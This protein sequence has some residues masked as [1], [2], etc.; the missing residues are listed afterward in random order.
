MIG[1]LGRLLF[2]PGHYAYVGSA[3]GGLRG[4]LERHLRSEKKTRWHIDYLL[5]QAAIEAIV[6]CPSEERTECR[7]ARALAARFEAVPGFGA[8]DCRCQSHLF[9]DGP[10]MRK[11]VLAAVK[12]A[13]LE[14]RLMVAGANNA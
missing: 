9:F 4:R 14:S 5:R 13:S 3:L 8:S 11:G 1:N 6:A 10:D 2:H 7:I 12:E